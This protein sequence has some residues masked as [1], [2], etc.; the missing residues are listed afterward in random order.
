MR[1]PLPRHPAGTAAR[2]APAA[3][4][5]LRAGTDGALDVLHPLLMLVRGLARLTVLAFRWWARAPKDRRGPALFFAAVAVMAV[6]LLPWGPPLAAA[7]LLGAAVWHGRDGARPP[8]RPGREEEEDAR[9]QAVYEAL[10]PC[11]ALRDDP[12]PE[13]LY[14]H[15]GAWQRAFEEAEFTDEGR[16][17][18]LL[19]HY[20]AH[21]PDSDPHYR[22]AVER[23]LAAKSGRDREYR[24]VWHEE[25]N[26]LEMTVPEP[27]PQGIAAQRFVTGPGEIVLGFTDAEAVPRRIPVAA[28][29][30]ALD[31]PPVVWRTGARSAQPHLLVVGAPGAGS[32]TL[33]RSVVLQALQHGEVLLVDGGG[34]GEFVSLAGR[35]G[36]LAVETSPAGAVASL[37]WAVHETERRLSAASSARR[38]GRPVPDDARRPLWVVLD[39][40]AALSHLARAEGRR[41]P[42]ELLQVPLR[43]GRAAQVTVA[44]AE[45]S[46]S[47]DGLSRVV[48]SCTR[49][50]VLLG[51]ASPEEARTALGETAVP[52]PCPYAP[53]GRGFAR[54]GA[55]AVLRLQVPAAPD[56]LDEAAAE[57]E[58]EAVRAL[59]PPFSAAQAGAAS[60]RVSI[61]KQGGGPEASSPA[62]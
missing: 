60:R 51:S 32:T 47:V 26:L 5:A 35:E 6:G 62:T 50:R 30:R 28:G 1:W 57:S 15:D 31:V 11:F 18:R 22:L 59:L 19:V 8:G 55:G 21:F 12:G 7:L 41:D 2:A 13:P 38:A 42:Q 36:V 44:V 45:H 25:R 43:H 46:E 40:P 33:L 39:R 23:R 54:L 16:I 4:R 53:P 9:L 3:R 49:A 14:A 29:G 34:S 48:H 56:P 61:A 52:H 24:F 27:L 17:A 10:V 20:P 58:R 37:E